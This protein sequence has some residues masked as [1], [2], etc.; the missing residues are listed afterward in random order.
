MQNINVLTIDVEDWFHILDSP[1]VPDF[2]KWGDLELRAHIGLERLLQLFE[3]T[4]TKATFFWLGWTAERFPKLVRECRESGHEIASHGY[5]HLLA[6]KVGK[7]R[8]RE[9]IRKAKH[10]LEDITGDYVFGFRAPGFGI[11]GKTPWAFSTIREIGYIYDS[12]I[13]PA[14]RGHGGISGSPLGPYF[15]RTDR[16]LIAEI[17][18]SVIHFCHK[19]IGLFGGGYLR[20]AT[21]N[22]I[23]WAIK[24]LRR[25][26]QPLILYV[27]PREVDPD[28]PRLALSLTR[29]FKCY[30]N[31]K[32]TMPKVTWLCNNQLF[33]TMY[34]LF[35]RCLNIPENLNSHGIPIF[36]LQPRKNDKHFA[37]VNRR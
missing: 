24:R 14:N 4:N 3:D 35:E 6:Y 18:M 34:D 7:D 1:A 8:F 20:L 13:F 15:I 27:H 30:V 23:D 17:P 9:D 25:S 36:E 32:S 28:H 12:S 10:I 29:K 2:R 19:R 31:L 16:G 33:C 37:F 22:L 5:S 21:K 26:N 11:T